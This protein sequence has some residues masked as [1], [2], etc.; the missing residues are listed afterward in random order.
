IN[1][2]TKNLSGD[3]DIFS[4]EG[5]R[6]L[7]KMVVYADTGESETGRL[8]YLRKP[9]RL[10]LRIEGRPPGDDAATFRFKFGGAFVAL[11]AVKP[12][13]EEKPVVTSKKEQTGI[14]VNSVGTIIE[15]KPKQVPAKTTVPEKPKETPVATNEVKK[16]EVKSKKEVETT[17]KKPVV[18][19]EELPKTEA[20]TEPVKEE[21]RPVAT[22]LSKPK[23]DSSTV[24]KPAK[25]VVQ[26]PIKAEEKKPDPLANIR[27]VIELK[28]GEV[29]E[30]RL[31][32]VTKFSVDNGVLTV[33]AKNG[34]I[35]RYSMLVVAKVTIE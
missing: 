23:K 15:T 13:E 4:A 11:K 22:V 8:I 34:N 26:P 14:R 25:K 20:K 31:N 12:T 17:A 29:I 19:E 28:S 7:T 27:L 21:P 16:E 3:I 24:A 18:V 33:I 32:E 9:E 10:L 5:L 6:P 1:V 35:A 2:V 30:H